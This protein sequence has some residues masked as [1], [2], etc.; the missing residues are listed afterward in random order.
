MPYRSCLTCG[1]L[2]RSGSYCRRHRPSR[3]NPARGSGGKAATFRRRTL[4]KTGGAC[5]LCGSTDG[6]QAHHVDGLAD[7]GHQ[8][9][10]GVP[11]CRRGH[12]KVTT[13]QRRAR[14]KRA[15]L[16]PLR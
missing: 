15:D 8:E 4:A 11:L 1:A 12:A 2:I 14:G 16:R 7:G 3:F 13:A 9:G 10:E 6:V 5:A